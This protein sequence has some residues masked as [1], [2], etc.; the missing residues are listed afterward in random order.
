VPSL[1]TVWLGAVLGLVVGLTG[2]GS[3]SL[4]TP[5]LILDGGLAPTVAVGTSLLVSFVTK[6]YGSWNFYRRGM[7]DMAILREL[8]LGCLPGALGGAVLVRYLGVHRPDT[9][10]HI[11]L[12]VIGAS[13]IFVSA[14]MLLRLLR[15]GMRGG[16]DPVPFFKRHHKPFAISVGFAVGLVFSLTSVG[17]GAGLIPLMV[18]CY[19]PL[20]SGTLVGT[21][22]FMGTVL[23]AIAGLPH[24]GIGNVDWKAVSGLLIGSVPAMWIAGHIHTRIPRQV[25]EGLIAAAL[26][27]MGVHIVSL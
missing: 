17:S 3:G 6:A 10:Q 4:L 12:R 21:S 2:M 13:L 27:A 5:L 8:S 18:L 25:P 9:L 15:G 26:L 14:G 19:G 24:A 23:A 7:V 20:E 11:V 22:V 1:T 16:T